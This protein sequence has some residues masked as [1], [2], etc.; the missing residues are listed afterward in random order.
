MERLLNSDAGNDA[1]RQAVEATERAVAVVAGPGTGKTKTLVERI[2]YLIERRGVKPAEITA[3][4]FT[5]QAALEMRE[6]LAAR[7]GG[8]KN[9]RGMTVGT[10]H[11]V[12]LQLLDKKTL[13]GEGELLDLAKDLLA[14][15][16]ER[17]AAREFLRRVSRAKS[18]TGEQDALCEAAGLPP[19][20]FCAW[21]ARLQALDARDL[22]DLLLDALSLDTAKTRGFSHLLVDEFQDVN[23]V[24]RRLT[25][26]FS[27]N[28]TLFVIGDPDQSIY[29]FR[30]ADAG[31]FA[32]LAQE[33]P[34]LRVVRLTENYRSTPEILAAA[35]AAIEQNPGGPRPLCANCPSGA[36]VRLLS[37]RDAFSQG[38]FIAREVAR[39]TGG[40][41]MLSAQSGGPQTARAFSEIAVL[42]RTRRQLA[43]IETCL[44]HDDI[45]CVVAGREDFWLDDAVRGA[46]AFFRWL[47]EPGDIASLRGCLRL[48][49]ACEGAQADRAAALCGD[50]RDPALLVQAVSPLDPLAAFAADAAQWLPRVR[51]EKP[52][53][54]LSQYAAERGGEPL[55][56]LADAAVFFADLRDFLNN[57]LT[58][59][60]GDVRRAAGKGDLSGAVRLMTLH[61]AK[62]LE[63]P[64]VFL[65]G[66]NDGALPLERAGE[67]T[68]VSEERRLFY[69]GLTRAREELIVTYAGEPSA[70]AREMTCVSRAAI[71]ASRSEGTQ[72]SLF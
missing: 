57:L 63:F 43:L 46:L 53:K 65:A 51:K 38:V 39:M 66:V 20:L 48:V 26:H 44:R 37:A 56:R 41:D 10:F 67:E 69:V 30:G 28:G 9:L 1:Q 4:T 52:H 55:R 18:E 71:P 13:L 33:L 45:P 15:R 61:G 8:K 70:F 58:G 59:Q 19:A 21:R 27:K 22:D 14:E 17:M 42:C 16:G 12:C 49:Y 50:A 54:L 60:E 72:L 35:R 31:C 6:R 7:L 64:V 29:G 47:L 68:D 3:V 36:P 32:R 40:L 62:G 24:Q 34:D 5:N 11:A 25:R 23:A 2:A